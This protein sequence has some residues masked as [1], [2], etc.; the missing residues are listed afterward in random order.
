V[1]LKLTLGEL[2][3]AQA[4]PNGDPARD[5]CHE[6]GWDA[7]KGPD[8]PDRRATKAI[9]AVGEQP[10]EERLSIVKAVDSG[11]CREIASRREPAGDCQE[12]QGVGPSPS[13][14]AAWRIEEQQAETQGDSEDVGLP[15]QDAQT[16]KYTRA[17]GRSQAGCRRDEK[18]QCAE[19]SQRGR[20]DVVSVSAVGPERPRRRQQGCCP[21]RQGHALREPIGHNAE[22]RNGYRRQ[23]RADELQERQ[24]AAGAL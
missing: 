10:T 8:A 12:S 16:H 15:Q 6:R 22:H 5:G 24:R 1:K 7:V 23:E 20:G 9:A 4:I 3:Q 19:D 13:P 17:N 21:E 2:P 11:S 18:G 14:G